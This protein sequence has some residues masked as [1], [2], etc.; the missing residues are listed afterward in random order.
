MT[1]NSDD[2]LAFGSGVIGLG[3]VA[4]RQVVLACTAT[5]SLAPSDLSVS[6]LPR[7][8]VPSFGVGIG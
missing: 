2:I 7:D 4:D 8:F 6:R 5:S 3:P 1:N